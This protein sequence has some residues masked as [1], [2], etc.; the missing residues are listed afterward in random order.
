MVFP[1]ASSFLQSIRVSCCSHGVTAASPTPRTW[2]RPALSSLAETEASSPVLYGH[3][4]TEDFLLSICLRLF[5]TLT[6]WVS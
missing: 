3:Q 4:H 1:P 5:T 6:L 2:A